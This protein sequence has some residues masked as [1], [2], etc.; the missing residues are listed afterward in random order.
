MIR[1]A[2]FRLT[3]I[4][5]RSITLGQVKRIPPIKDNTQSEAS[6]DS[7]NEAPTVDQPFKLSKV[8]PRYWRKSRRRNEAFEAHHKNKAMSEMQKIHTDKAFPVAAPYSQAI[9]AGGTIY[10]SG[11]IPGG[12]DGKLVEGNIGDKTAACCKNIIAILEAAGS[13]IERV[14]KVNIFLDDMANFKEMNETYG[15][16]FAHKPARSCV[17]VKALP[18][19]VP[20]EIECIALAGKSN[21]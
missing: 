13:S 16:Y 1:R 2:F 6:Q 3:P 10:V 19:G 9:V 14:V 21:L 8:E 18:L 7:T 11:Q 15:V 12:A 17:A 4:Q 20:V 5:A